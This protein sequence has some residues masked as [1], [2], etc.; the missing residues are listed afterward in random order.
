MTCISFDEKFNFKFTRIK[1]FEIWL[2]RLR[3]IQKN[4]ICVFQFHSIFQM[5]HIYDSHALFTLDFIFLNKIRHIYDFL[6]ILLSMTHK[7]ESLGEVEEDSIYS[8]ILS[9]I[10][11]IIDSKI[12]RKSWIW[13]ILF[14]KMKIWVNYACES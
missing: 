4:T 7:H 12:L 13:R 6:K 9:N 14:K 2:D 8:L 1:I 10:Y 3:K 5:S 11:S